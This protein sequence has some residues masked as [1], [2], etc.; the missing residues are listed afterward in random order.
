VSRTKPYLCSAACAL[1]ACVLVACAAAA[2]AP[3]QPKAFGYTGWD[4]NYFYFAAKVEDKSVTGTNVGA[5][6][7]PWE[8]DSVELCFDVTGAGAQAPDEGC[9]R[10][11]ISA[12]GGFTALIGT[13]Q[14]TWRAAPSWLRGLR[15]DAA[16]RGTLNK[17]QDNDQG[18]VVEVAIPWQHLGGEPRP[19]AEIGFAFALHL[20]GDQDGFAS[21]CPALD[22]EEG[23]DVPAAWCR[24]TFSPRANPQVAQAGQIG[25]PRM[26]RPP[27]VDGVLSAVEWMGASVL[28]ITLPEATAAAPVGRAKRTTSVMAL[29]T[30][31][32][33]DSTQWLEQPL[34]GLGP[35][36]NPEQ[37]AWHRS[38]VRQVRRAAIDTL[39]VAWRPGDGAAARTPL[40][41]LVQALITLKQEKYTY[42]LLALYLDGEQLARVLPSRDLRSPQSAQALYAVIREFFL[43]VPPE[44]RAQAIT[45]R[46]RANLVLIGE[47]QGIE[48]W[49]AKFA[50]QCGQAFEKDFGSV[51]MWLGDR[52]WK[53]KGAA[54]DACWSAE[55][56]LGVDPC[57]E[58]TMSLLEG[59]P[60]LD[61]Y[62]TD[63]GQVVRMAPDFVLINS[64]ND[65]PSATEICPSRQRGWNH[66]DATRRYIV[67][68]MARGP[69][70][71][72]VR[73]DTLP[74]IIPPGG[75]WQI[76][77]LLTNYTLADLS[78]ARDISFQYAL[79][80]EKDRSAKASGDAARSLRLPAGATAPVL[81]EIYARGKSG[82]LPPGPY[83][84]T[85]S[86]AR[87]RLPILV[88]PL[89]QQSIAQFSMPVTIG[90]PPKWA[91]SA[92]SST[93]PARIQ[94]GGK[95]A[96]QVRLR[97]DG[98]SF[99]QKGKVRLAHRWASLD[100]QALPGQRSAAVDLPKDVTSGQVVSM[101][102]EI[103]APPEP[104]VQ[105]INWEV[106][107]GDQV[108][109]RAGEQAALVVAMEPGAR[110][111]RA[112]IARTMQAGEQYTASIV[113]GNTGPDTWKP[114]QVSI[115]AG[116]HYLD[117]TSAGPASSPAALAARTAPGSLG[118]VRVP[119]QAPK[120]GGSYLLT[121]TTTFAGAAEKQQTAQQP[122]EPIAVRVTGGPF[123][124]VDLSQFFNIAAITTPQRRSSGEFDGAGRS[125][126]AEYVPPDAATEPGGWYP[127][128]YYGSQEAPRQIPLL[129]PKRKE[130]RGGAV[131]CNGQ[132]IALPA[133][134]SRVHILAAASSEGVAAEF[135]LV[136]ASGE[137]RPLQ[138][139][140][141][142]WMQPPASAQEEGLAVPLIRTATADEPKQAYLHHYVLEAHQ[143]VTL[144]LPKA[145][146]VRLVALTIER[147]PRP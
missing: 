63:L 145:A 47:P 141:A 43:M 97:N 57:T 8:D 117:G 61:D 125:L 130:G 67:Q 53:D 132:A 77:L 113:L 91:A 46:G 128:G 11:V 88:N 140:V 69:S 146:D 70:P 31:P 126:P 58:R 55:K 36:W 76:E 99:W 83:Q 74:R 103:A 5:F 120:F 45:E 37:V 1:V 48:D 13:A 6:S 93:L 66:V 137:R 108:L 80:G 87:S 59:V 86:L 136:T 41:C 25:C 22:S 109:C 121:F 52:K 12:A 142:N 34:E 122:L 65:F 32:H 17:P 95:Y 29:Y 92:I 94:A 102:V 85:L 33:L 14:G 20:R 110:L 15:F 82:L 131:A 143:A 105:V 40:S 129:F 139:T 116:W 123:E 118:V 100:G 51:L 9:A 16:V 133:G 104:G 24:L 18:Y 2:E 111:V 75:T 79:R 78:T 54:L 42:P 4:S 38:Q 89:W 119:V 35:W 64:W 72:G 106:R 115:T 56:R 144:E 26:L 135:V 28:P 138:V 84:L 50:Q 96:V 49:D 73:R 30:F 127:C 124:P 19:E 23:L 134:A 10:M 7:Q 44:F 21:C 3:Q 107:Q 101:P 147:T 27:T 90:S 81:A 68:L 98:S 39:A 71:V 62:Q 112:E 60:S 114:G